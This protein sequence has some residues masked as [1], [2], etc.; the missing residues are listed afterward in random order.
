MEIIVPRAS[1][2]INRLNNANFFPKSI[3][4]NRNL[5][6]EFLPSLLSIFPYFLNFAMTMTILYPAE[7]PFFNPNYQVSGTT[8]ATP[9]S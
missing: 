7:V 8:N 1:L 2:F 5:K 3:D 4:I 6:N 9:Y